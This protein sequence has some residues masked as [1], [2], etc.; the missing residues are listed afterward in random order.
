MSPDEVKAFLAGIKGHR[1]ESLF[2]VALAMGLRQGELLGLRWEDVD[3]VEST[4]HVRHAIQRVNG[5]LTL[6]ERKTERSRRT[7]H[8]PRIAAKALRSQR[9]RQTRSG[10]RLVQR[11]NDHGFIFSTSIGTPLD[12]RNVIRY[13][14]RVLTSTG[15]PH[16]RFHSLRHSCASLL[17]AQHVPGRTVMELLGHSEIRLTLD[18]YSHVMPQLMSEAANAMDEALGAV[19]S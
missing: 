12:A 5:K 13:S 4:V 7:L 6:T 1:F 2:T 9:V 11:W 8:L 18:T 14:D 16:F 19:E 17:L 3:I 15:L 10:Y